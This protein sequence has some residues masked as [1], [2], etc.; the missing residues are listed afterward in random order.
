MENKPQGLDPEIAMFYVHHAVY[1]T[2]LETD[3]KMYFRDIMSLVH[4]RCVK[5]FNRRIG[6]W[7]DKE[8]YV[9]LVY[10]KTDATGK[11]DGEPTIIDLPDKRIEAYVRSQL[12]PNANAQQPAEPIA[13]G[14]QGRRRSRPAASRGRAKKPA[15]IVRG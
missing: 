15:A 8:G 2:T 14:G 13:G 9:H 6:I 12:R 11:N 5:T 4:D 10:Y 3:R 1:A 7:M